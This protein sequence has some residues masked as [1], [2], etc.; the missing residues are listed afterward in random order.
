[1]VFQGEICESDLSAIQVEIAEEILTE[2]VIFPISGT[3]TRIVRVKRQDSLET[4]RVSKE[5]GISRRNELTRVGTQ[6]KHEV[7][8]QQTL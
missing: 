8:Y 1:M 3:V 5:P 4:W 6:M 2:S 7:N